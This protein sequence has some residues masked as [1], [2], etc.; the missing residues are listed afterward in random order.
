MFKV[1]KIAKPAFSLWIDISRTIS[2]DAFKF[3]VILSLD[4]NN[5]FPKFCILTTFDSE[6]QLKMTPT[7]KLI[8][9]ELQQLGHPN[10]E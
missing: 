10:F 7:E 3:C 8:S 6:N 5:C 1:R 2:V 9:H 4:L